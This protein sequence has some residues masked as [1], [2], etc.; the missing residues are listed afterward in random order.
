MGRGISSEACEQSVFLKPQVP[1]G[2]P[3]SKYKEEN[4]RRRYVTLTTDFTTDKKSITTMWI[5]GHM[6]SR[7]KT[8]GSGDEQVLTKSYTKTVCNSLNK[9]NF[10]CDH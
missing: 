6:L 1:V 5:Q 4:N 2:K 8:L 3:V 10:V 7:R 9:L